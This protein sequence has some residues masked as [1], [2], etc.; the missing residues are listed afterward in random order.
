MNALTAE[1]F[2]EVH[3]SV[4]TE[5]R[6]VCLPVRANNPGMQEGAHLPPKGFA[7]MYF[8]SP[9]AVVL[10][11]VN[12]IGRLDKP[13]GYLLQF[14]RRADVDDAL[15]KIN[16]DASPRRPKG[17]R[18]LTATRLHPHNLPKQSQVLDL[19]RKEKVVYWECLMGTVRKAQETSPAPSEMSEVLETVLD[20]ASPDEEVDKESAYSPSLESD[21]VIDVGNKAQPASS[22]DA[23]SRRRLR[24]NTSSERDMTSPERDLTSSPELDITSSAPPPESEQ[25]C[26]LLPWQ[27]R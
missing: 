18:T 13:Q 2:C 9:F 10:N 1:L 6:Q 22:H 17:K 15:S 26:E 4:N 12:V 21:G 16:D 5:Q 27:T 7:A 24:A 3:L 14:R 19:T 25:D 11:S 8:C 23:R 20:N